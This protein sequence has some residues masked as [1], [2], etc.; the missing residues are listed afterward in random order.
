MNFSSKQTPC[1]QQIQGWPS[2]KDKQA[3]ARDGS[4]VDSASRIKSTHLAQL[5]PIPPLRNAS[6][7]W[8]SFIL[9]QSERNSNSRSGKKARYLHWD[10]F[11]WA[12]YLRCLLDAKKRTRLREKDMVFHVLHV[13]ISHCIGCWGWR[14]R[15]CPHGVWYKRLIWIK[16]PHK[17]ECIQTMM[18]AIK[19]NYEV[20]YE[21]LT[22]EIS[23]WRSQERLLF[24]KQKWSWYT[25][26]E[27]E[28]TKGM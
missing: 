24:K 13:L 23:V 12:K 16:E 22:E 21:L 17:H 27:K 2:R 7:T 6:V 10:L 5:Y 14:H 1:T 15:P 11:S 19:E 28:L 3:K 8:K 18:T 9:R 20:F 26:N 25:K 4:G